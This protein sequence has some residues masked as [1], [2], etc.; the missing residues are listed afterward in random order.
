MGIFKR[1]LSAIGWSSSDDQHDEDSGNPENLKVKI[2]DEENN[3]TLIFTGEP[4]MNTAI[5]FDGQNRMSPN[6]I[7]ANSQ[8]NNDIKVAA[9]VG[10]QVKQSRQPSMAPS[11]PMQQP[12]QMPPQPMAPQQPPQQAYVNPYAARQ[13]PPQQPYYQQAQQQPYYQQP[14]QHPYYQQPPQP[15]YPGNYAQPGEPPIDDQT[16]EPYHEM[17]LVN[18]VYHLYVDLPGVKKQGLGVRYVNSE[19]EV[20]GQRVSMVDVW[21]NKLKGNKG[22]KPVF[23]SQSTVPDYLLGKFKF[24]FYFPLPVDE[25]TVKAE[26]EESALLHVSMKLRA[27]AGGV[28]VSVT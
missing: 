1:I 19:I 22:K 15:Q 9:A 28:T 18:D 4:D 20:T 10:A 12:R 3:S 26:L 5:G 2:M 24:S 25:Q 13:Q 23:E 16:P 14:P 21:R 17:M 27:S 8:I 7:A 11:A 6:M